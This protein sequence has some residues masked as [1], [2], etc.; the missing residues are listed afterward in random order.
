MQNLQRVREVAN[1]ICTVFLSGSNATSA[2][3]KIF[4]LNKFYVIFIKL[5][6]SEDSIKYL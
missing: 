2:I 1:E 6:Y 4:I 3:N 5:F